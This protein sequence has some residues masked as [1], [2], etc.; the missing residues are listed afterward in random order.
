M[1][2]VTTAEGT[3]AAPLAVGESLAP[4]LLVLEHVRR[5]R[6]LDVYE[7]RDTTRFC[8]VLVKTP[9]PELAVDP[10][11]LASL[12]HEWDVLARLTHP[13][14]VRG[15]ELVRPE[16]APPRLVLEVLTGSTFGALMA[17]L[18]RLTL[19]ELAQLTDHLASALR[20]LHSL[21]FLHLDVKPSNVVCENGIAKLLDFSIARPPGTY[22]PGLGTR[23]W[24]S[25]E[26]LA[27]EELTSAS[28]VWGLGLLL[29]LGAT[30][31]NPYD[32]HDEEGLPVGARVPGVRSV[33]R[34]PA[35]VAAAMDACLA[36]A[37]GDRP[38]L[39]ELA[40]V[41]APHLGE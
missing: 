3:V 19:R 20:Y 40:A 31:S 29:R 38:T 22:R 37:P 1:C 11:T 34:L 8:R 9:R 30:G 17:D 12:E 24:A 10:G 32:H 6:D 36:R 21:G 39:P 5:G 41:F 23:T 13:H 15:Y 28:D 2:P 7:A 4:S 16:G 35:P 18:G 26:Q 27:G 14:M 25:P 33:R